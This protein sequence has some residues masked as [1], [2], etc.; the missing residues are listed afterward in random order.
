MVTGVEAAG[1]ALAILPLIV[2]QLD[3]YAKGVETS[4]L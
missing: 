3:N 1:L 2:N 4:R